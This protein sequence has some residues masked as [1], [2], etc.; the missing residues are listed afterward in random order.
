MRIAVWHNLPS[1]GGKRALH[2]HVRGL[3]MR[4]H[5]VEAWSPPTAV[6]TYMPLSRYGPEHVVP[7]DWQPEWHR[8][9]IIHNFNSYLNAI[10]KIEAMKQ[11]A[12]RCVAEIERGGF[13]LIFANTCVIFATSFIARFANIPTVLYLQEPFRMFYE[14]QSFGDM[15][16]LAWVASMLPYFKLAK[17]P[18]RWKGQA[19]SLVRDLVDVHALRLQAREEALSAWAFDRIL[20]NSRFSREAIM[21][22]YGLDARVCYLGIDTDLFR[23]TGAPKEQ[24]VVGLGSFNVVKGIDL[25]IRAIAT[26]DAALRPS[27]VWIGNAAVPG[28]LEE[29]SQLAESLGVNFLPKELV[30]QDELVDLLSR[31]AVMVYTSRLEPFGY[32]PLEANACETPVVG[33]A[34]GGIRESIEPGINGSL[35][36]TGDPIALG[37]RIMRYVDNLDISRSEGL[38]A[39]NHILK[40][41]QVELAVERLEMHLVEV[42]QA[43]Q[44]VPCPGHDTQGSA[45]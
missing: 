36:E 40:T 8:A 7:F 44:Q 37:Q 41:W 24:F 27:L 42:L 13:D 29:M 18:L 35:I 25:A 2:D 28:Y 23:P 26:V 33:I 6:L 39:R 5:Q 31:A 16:R 9:P 20:C 11:H 32:A 3:V 34:E 15:T 1:G 12:Q 19:A 43:K 22:V 17:N 21:R 10:A 4:G 45:M 38:K 14:A 30:G